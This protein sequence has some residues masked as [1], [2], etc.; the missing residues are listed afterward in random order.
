MEL[1]VGVEKAE[2]QLCSEVEQFT[3]SIRPNINFIL[4]HW[5]QCFLLKCCMWQIIKLIGTLVHT[6]F[7]WVNLHA[8][9]KDK[10]VT[11]LK[12]ITAKAV[13]VTAK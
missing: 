7:Q 8:K 9:I 6:P 11:K 2:F 12:L 4:R 10:K 13:N 3:I 5:S 1:V